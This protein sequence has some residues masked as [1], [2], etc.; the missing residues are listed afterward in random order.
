MPEWNLIKGLILPSVLSW[1]DSRAFPLNAVIT[2]TPP[3][4][5]IECMADL[6]DSTVIGI[7]ALNAEYEEKSRYSTV[8]TGRPLRMKPRWRIFSP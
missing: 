1:S 4:Q 8:M 5:Y 6:S 2:G 3:K 7:K